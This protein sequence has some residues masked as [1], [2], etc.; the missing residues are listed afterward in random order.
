MCEVS[1][2][3]V[4]GQNFNYDHKEEL[5]PFNTVTGWMAGVQFPAA[6]PMGTDNSSGQGMS[7]PLTCNYCRGQHVS[8]M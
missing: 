2:K 3:S 7:S 4:Q 8:M 1:S 6:H 5:Q